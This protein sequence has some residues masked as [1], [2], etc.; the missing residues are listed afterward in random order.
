M[1]KKIA[2]RGEQELPALREA[3]VKVMESANEA[4]GLIFRK[5]DPWAQDQQALLAED[6]WNGAEP[7]FTE[8]MDDFHSAMEGAWALAG[9]NREAWYFVYSVPPITRRNSDVEYVRHALEITAM[10]AS[11]W[12][13]THPAEDDGLIVRVHE[14]VLS[15]IPDRVLLWYVLFLMPVFECIRH[16][17]LAL[18]A[19]KRGEEGD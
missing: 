6:L 10:E 14:Y 13:A 5:L 18:Q 9:K 2:P 12:L 16:P 3:L 19:N 7:V 15:K 4:R 1:S 8:L 11:F 17:W